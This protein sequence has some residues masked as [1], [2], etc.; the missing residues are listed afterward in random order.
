MHGSKL[1]LH[2]WFWAVFLMTTEPN[3]ITSKALQEKLRLSSYKS[4]WL[5]RDK[6][7]RAVANRDIG[8]E[9][10]GEN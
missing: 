1:P 8:L 3:E 9:S 10:E 2:I 7:R 6:I 5:L 4:A